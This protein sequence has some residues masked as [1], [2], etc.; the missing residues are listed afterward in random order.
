MS[1]ASA[2]IA[3][4]ASIRLVLVALVGSTTPI[5]ATAREMGAL[6][7][8]RGFKKRLLLGEAGGWRNGRGGKLGLEELGVC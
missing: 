8:L 2:I 6:E 1:M 7:A 3:S 4:S 5:G